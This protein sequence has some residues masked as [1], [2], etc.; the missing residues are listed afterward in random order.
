ML[1]NNSNDIN[2]LIKE[3]DNKL[4]SSKICLNLPSDDIDLNLDIILDFPKS[5]V[6]DEKNSSDIKNNEINIEVNNNIKDDNNNQNDNKLKSKNNNL[7]NISS[8]KKKN[9]NENNE[10]LS[11]NQNINDNDKS[12]NSYLNGDKTNNKNEITEVQE[13]EINSRNEINEIVDNKKDEKEEKEN[14]I[15]IEEELRRE[16]ED[17]EREKE[18]DERRKNEEEKRKKREME[19]KEIEKEKE[20]EKNKKKESEKEEEKE[21]KEEKE[22]N[23]INEIEEEKKDEIKEKE[24]NKIN[25]VEEE[26]KEEIKEE[27]ICIQ[28][29][30]SIKPIEK[31]NKNSK[32]FMSLSEEQKNDYLSIINDIKNL[33]SEDNNVKDIDVDKYHTIIL[34]MNQK[35]ET[36]DDIIPNFKS[37][38]KQNENEIEKRKHNFISHNYFEWIIE[39]SPLLELIPCCK[40]SHVDLLNN[41]Y[42]EE[43]LHNLP[44]IN[45]DYEEL[46]FEN[47][48]ISEKN[49]P[50]GIIEDLESFIYKFKFEKNTKVAVNS[51]K[52]F[53][54]WRNINGD[55]NSFYRSFMFSLLEYY[56]LNNNLD[57]LNEIISEITSNQ[58]LEIYKKHELD[59]TIPF[60]ILGAILKLLSNNNIEKAYD[61]FIKSYLLKNACFDKM[62]IIYL[63][64]ISY[65]Y[66]DEVIEIS[67]EQNQPNVHNNINKEL[68][69][70]MNI[71]PSFFIICLMPYLYDINIH[72]FWLDK[73]LI[74]CKDGVINFID[75]DN[76]E[77]LPLISLG[78]FF[79]SYHI[80]Y[81]VKSNNEFI[82][83]I[84]NSKSNSLSRLTCQINNKNKCQI[85]K[86]QKYIIFLK[87]NFKVC[88]NCLEKYINKISSFR[89]ESL[90]NDNYIGQ[91][92]YS[93]PFHLKDNYYL[94]DFEFIEI[95]EEVN[96]IN[97]LQHT[98]SIVCSKC[99][100]NFD[101]KNLNNLKCKCLLCDKCLEETILDITGG[102]KILNSY[103]KRNLQKTLCTSCEGDFS[104]ED[105][106]EHLKDIKEKDRK[107]AINR[108]KNYISTKCLICGTEV[109]KNENFDEFLR[110][111]SEETEEDNNNNQKNKY[112]ELKKF[113]KLKIRKENDKRKGIDYL[114]IE[115]VICYEC[116]EKN[117]IHSNISYSKGS[118]N[119]N[120]DK[121]DDG[122]GSSDDEDNKYKRGEYYVD[123]EEGECFC[124]IC[125]KKHYLI[126]KS[127]R[128]GGCCSSGCNIN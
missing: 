119:N 110:D 14:R 83:K 125:N 95:K 64:Y 82:N 52:S 70:T 42:N 120:K 37:I 109:R 88:K 107:N 113:R 56:I 103:E 32:I 98:A 65:I 58:L 8:E 63:K 10:I 44:E 31:K 54:F 76:T 27:S 100:G 48:I 68:I 26:K 101:K 17:K 34:D 92:F 9:K 7:N 5:K 61:L 51:L 41:I 29:E 94:N 124:S 66:V 59:Y 43:G 45:D 28:S 55:G 15:I 72:I 86:G 126:D 123:F 13:E 106:L 80:I 12:L 99:K 16:N 62:L 127:V 47:E 4:V 22:E 105:A 87:K 111:N 39:A 23:E 115:H 19:R 93:R 36:L 102:L 3:L 57:E 50:I 11:D 49:S 122:L 69:N 108:M 114:D 24:E 121:E 117:M 2:E 71:E 116:Y 90:N 1:D 46:I 128:N 77:N 25:E 53:N 38:I 6:K 40:I 18:E 112:I 91:E 75:E 84:F 104:Y 78:Y 79:S 81:S 67:K 97:Y 20:K 73:D 118:V 30:N 60:I 85:C 35:E 89:N 33:K 74:Q 21:E 96:I